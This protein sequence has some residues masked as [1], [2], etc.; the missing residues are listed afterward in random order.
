LCK[1]N[2]YDPF[3]NKEDNTTYDVY[4]SE[5]EITKLIRILFNIFSRNNIIS[6]QDII[7]NL[8]KYRQKFI[9]FALERLIT[10]RIPIYDRF[11][12][13][14]YIHED[15]GIFYLDRNYPNSNE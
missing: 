1:Y 8:P 11:G 14:S 9:I 13:K 7:N 10:N 12:Y 3:P 4:Y 5:S 15:R 6:F 2:C